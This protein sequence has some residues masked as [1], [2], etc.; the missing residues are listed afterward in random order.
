M[1]SFYGFG[2]FTV[3]PIL[4]KPL[5]CYR[6]II[7]FCLPFQFKSESFPGDLTNICKKKKYILAVNSKIL[8]MVSWSMVKILVV[9]FVDKSRF[10]TL[11]DE[12]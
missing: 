12:L 2:R 5:F 11:F 8:P 7:V 9:Q 4:L 3:H 6:T 1:N 10:A